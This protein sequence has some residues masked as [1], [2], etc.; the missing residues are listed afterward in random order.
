MTDPAKL[1]EADL[2][3]GESLITYDEIGLQLICA[4][5]TDK[6]QLL[7]NVRTNIQRKGL[8]RVWPCPPHDDEL[9]IVAGGPSLLD[10][11]DDLKAVIENGAKCVALANATHLLLDHGIRP[12]AQVILDAKPRN[13]EFAIDVP[14][15]TYL[16]ASQCDPSVFDKVMGFSQFSG[17]DGFEAQEGHQRVML[18]NAVNNDDELKAVMSLGEPWV[19]VQAGSTITLRALRLFQILGYHRFHLFGFDSCMMDGKHHAYPQPSADNLRLAEVGC[20][21]RRFTVSGWQINQAMEFIK[22]CKLFAQELEMAVYG[23][24]L[25]AHMVRSTISKQPEAA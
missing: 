22:F 19:P 11:M 16:I 9:A 18:W 14:D 4:L 23:D 13:A 15:C 20:N 17:Y 2:G 5:N 8:M 10:T 7:E 24:G 1:T 21:G 12:S 25:I 6:E 3:P